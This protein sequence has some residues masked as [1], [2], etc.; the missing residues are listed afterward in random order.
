MTL[1]V[2]LTLPIILM[3]VG[4]PLEVDQCMKAHTLKQN[5]LSFSKKPSAVNNPQLRR[6]LLSISQLQA[7]MLL[8]WYLWGPAEVLTD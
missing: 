2:Q 3:G 5:W 8:P 6:S 4:H 7:R 1:Q